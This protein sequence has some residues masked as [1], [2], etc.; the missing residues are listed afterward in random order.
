MPRYFFDTQERRRRIR[1]EIGLD[2]R[3]E[4]TAISEASMI[5]FQLLEKAS[6][7]RKPGA[8]AISIRTESGDCLYE[9]ST[10]SSGD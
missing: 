6:A 4:A 5:I 2:L 8:V 10:T 1:D 9:A 3:D 7:E